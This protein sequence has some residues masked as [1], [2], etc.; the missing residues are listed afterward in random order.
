[1]GRVVKS[2]ILAAGY[3]AG[4]FE[5]VRRWQSWQ[6][7]FPILVYHRVVDDS[8]L[9]RV[10]SSFRLRGLTVSVSNFEKQIKYLKRKYRLVSLAECVRRKKSG[11]SLANCAVVTFDDGYK[12]F[13]IL[14]WPV[15]KKYEV[16]VTIFF[17]KSFLEA[18]HWQHQLYYILDEAGGKK[19]LISVGNKTVPLDLSGDEEKYQSIIGLLEAIR[20]LPAAERLGAVGAISK[21]LGVSKQLVSGEFYLTAEDLKLLAGAGIELGAHT[22]SHSDMTEL[23][24]Q[25]V[26]QEITESIAFIRNLTS[27]Q[28]IAFALPFS[29]G[30]GKVLEK[31]KKSGGLCSFGRAAG[32]NTAVDDIFQLKRIAAL[33]FS[34]AEFA[35]NVS[36]AGMK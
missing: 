2:M 19:A 18:V 14:A 20:K 34:I 31:I 28:E 12:D 15:I 9:P 33:D 6:G 35:Y 4:I 24:E 10:S 22:V 7:R 30:D 16:P 11:E 26:D 5:L 27:Q 13:L 17:P 25:Q 29:S 3:Y 21:T 1:M 23:S 36:G 8:V 32:L